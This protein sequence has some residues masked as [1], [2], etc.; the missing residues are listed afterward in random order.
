MMITLTDLKQIPLFQH[1]S[2]RETTHLLESLEQRTLPT[3][4]ILFNMGDPGDELYI[5]GEGRVA[6]YVPSAETPGSE[7]PIRIF[8]AGEALGE[9]A[10]IDHQPRSLSARTLEPT[11]LFVL[12]GEEFQRLLIAQPELALS[13][14]MGL[15]DR[16]RYTTEFL[17]EVRSWVQRVAQGNYDRAWRPA[18]DYTDPSIAALAAEFTQM[19]AQVQQREEALRRELA[20]L[21]IEIDETKRKRHVEEI[22]ETDYFQT[23]Q[24]QARRLRQEQKGSSE[25][26]T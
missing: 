13:V 24:A 4:S 9:M 20:Q 12:T 19:A 17:N 11:T 18:W 1:L 16:V 26:D 5:V 21:R 7:Q 14:M 8:E 25:S 2:E 6:I 10:L 22:V 23:L 15:S 3:G